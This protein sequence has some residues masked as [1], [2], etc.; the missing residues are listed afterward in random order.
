MNDGAPA[1]GRGSIA[2]VA[3]GFMHEFPDMV[4]T[5]DKLLANKY[6]RTEFHWTLSGTSGVGTGNA[7]RI[8]G[9]EDWQMDIHGL[10]SESKGNFDAVDYARQLS[11]QSR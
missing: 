5:F 1:I 10:I 2:E 11:A 7:V 4:V 9:Y 3:R 6:G 8:S